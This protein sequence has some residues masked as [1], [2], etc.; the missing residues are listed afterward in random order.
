MAPPDWRWQLYQSIGSTQEAA[1]AAALSGEPD[2]LA[3]L[4]ECQ[5]RGRGSRGRTWL[6]SKGNLN[7]SV[8]LRTAS[9]GDGPG[10]WALIAGLALHTALAAYCP[11]IVLKWPNDVLRGNAKLGGILIDSQWQSGLANWVVI[12][13]GANLATAPELEGRPAACLPPPAPP[14]KEVA[15]AILHYINRYQPCS[16]TDIRNAWLSRAHPV[17]TPLN[18]CTAQRC[19]NGTFAGLSPHG[20]LLLEGCDMPI[21]SAEIWPVALSAEPLSAGQTT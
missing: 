1:I 8:M 19:I 21:S 3:V 17:G 2:R 13:F 9:D 7:L 16:M 4:A 14:A 11:E 6:S 18:V 15:A 12:G 20:E 5:E 10:R